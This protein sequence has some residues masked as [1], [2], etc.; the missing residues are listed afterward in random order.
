MKLYGYEPTD[1]IEDVRGAALAE[2]TLNASPE[3][4]RRMAAFL[5]ACA[6]EMERMGDTY[7]HVHLSDHMLEFE[8]SPQFVVMR[9]PASSRIRWMWTRRAGNAAR[10]GCCSGR[11]SACPG[12]VTVRR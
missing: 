2:V 11:R 3:E 12:V 4:L 1:F 8:A 5:A 7:S 6:D 10:L 9:S